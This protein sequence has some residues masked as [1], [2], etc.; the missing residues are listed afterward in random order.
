[1]NPISN[2]EHISNMGYGLDT[3]KYFVELQAMAVLPSLDIYFKATYPFGNE[4]VDEYEKEVMK[5]L[6]KYNN[7][8]LNKI[9]KPHLSACEQIIKIWKE[10]LLPM[11]IG[12]R[13]EY[14]RK[15]N[16]DIN[17]RYELHCILKKSRF[18]HFDEILL[19]R[20]NGEKV[21][22]GSPDITT[23]RGWQEYNS[24]LC[25]MPNTNKKTHAVD[26][27]RF[28]EGIKSFLSNVSEVEI[29]QPQQQ[30][31]IFNSIVNE[32]ATKDQSKQGTIPDNNL[33][34]VATKDQSE[35]ATI[36]DNNLNEVAT[37]DQS[38]QITIPDHILTALQ[39]KGF[40][41][42]TAYP[43]KWLESKS[44]LA[45]FVEVTNDKLNLKH[46]LKRQIRPFETMFNKKG[47]TG[48]IND[49]KKT[50]QL[51][52]GYKIIDEIFDTPLK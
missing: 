36:P 45:Y 17:S 11:T 32:V 1:M 43:L 30:I 26:L 16:I 10:R 49:Y 28:A 12:F 19:L 51:P 20:I 48:R 4:A 3:I 52:I 14:C 2:M 50:G 27:V 47:L 13:A 37:K 35:Q 6:A 39:Q 22:M 15:N 9:L 34:E 21:E 41:E 18:S 7:G 25:P 29:E 33:N 31:V 38:E 44:L 8:G 46:G 23:G 24:E 5:C 40:I 42:A